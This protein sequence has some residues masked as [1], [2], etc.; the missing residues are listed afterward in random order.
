MIDEITI[1]NYKSIP[2]LKFSLGR[3]NVFIGANGAGK[4]N[5]LEAIAFGA[6]ASGNKL[7]SEFLTSRGIRV[8]DPRLMK[9]AFEFSDGKNKPVKI[10]FQRAGEQIEYVLENTMGK[11]AKW[12]MSSGQDFKLTDL[13][14]FL[15][16]EEK[17][18]DTGGNSEMGLPLVKGLLAL[19]K[20]ETDKKNLNPILKVNP[21]VSALFNKRFPTDEI[22]NFIIYSPEN[23]RLRKFDEETQIEPLGIYGEGLF[24]LLLNME[25]DEISK[26]KHHLQL[27]DWFEDFSIPN[28]TLSNEMRINIVDRFINPD[29]D[30]FDHKSTN[31]GFLFLL[32]YVTLIISK[33]TPSF[34]AIDNIDN[35]LNPKLCRQVMESIN[36]LSQEFDKQVM[37]TTHNPSVL[38]GLNLDDPDQRLYVVFRN[39]KGMTRL[40]RIDN[41]SFDTAGKVRLSEAF[42]RGYIGG[43]NKYSV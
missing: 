26:I 10:T 36:T 17:K 20:K 5:V 22:E 6:A 19:I 14:A 1:E 2:K 32:F 29:I 33:Y 8:S 42:I 38:D 23:N 31:E 43:L 16:E 35:S 15:E 34:F 21:A 18:A 41:E 27:I 9:S 7:G 39:A 40:K 37:I 11:Y 13:V 30:F 12:E 3:L 24:R 28:N 4:S 25:P